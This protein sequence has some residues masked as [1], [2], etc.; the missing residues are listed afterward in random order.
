MVKTEKSDPVGVRKSNLELFD[1]ARKAKRAVDGVSRFANKA[2]L[3]LSRVS[4]VI[5]KS[6]GKL[7]KAAPDSKRRSQRL[8]SKNAFRVAAS[9]ATQRAYALL[10]NTARAYGEEATS[11]S[12]RAPALVSL[13][14]GAVHQLQLF[15]SAYCQTAFA[16]V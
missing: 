16:K 15:L 14:P 12:K 11:D 10:D 9:G 13:A 1:L 6:T 2:P 5:D 3:Y 4:H 7:V 8:I